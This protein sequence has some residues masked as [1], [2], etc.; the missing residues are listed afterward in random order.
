M[1]TLT[2]DLALCSN[3]FNAISLIFYTFSYLIIGFTVLVVVVNILIYCDVSHHCAY[4]ITLWNLTTI[5][6]IVILFIGLFGI[7]ITV[8]LEYIERLDAS[9]INAPVVTTIWIYIFWSGLVF[10]FMILP[11]YYSF[12]TIVM[13]EKKL[14][15][16]CVK[17]SLYFIIQLKQN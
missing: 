8:A 15:K 2:I 1:K 13:N 6:Y 3:V 5:I 4:I 10:K 11:F 9:Q 12:N 7:P 16:K 14:C 17:T